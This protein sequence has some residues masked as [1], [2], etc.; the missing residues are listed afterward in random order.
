M[1]EIVAYWLL[2]KGICTEIINH[3]G[4]Q[5]VHLWQKFA[6]EDSGLSNLSSYGFVLFVCSMI[7]YQDY[8]WKGPH[9]GDLV[10]CY[11]ACWI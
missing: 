7:P 5:Y 1:P 8:N 2:E 11:L 9:F 3:R 10:V 4:N 6:S